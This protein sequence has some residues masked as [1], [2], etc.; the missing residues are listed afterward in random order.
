M[1]SGAIHGSWHDLERNHLE[2]VDGKFLPDPDPAPERPQVLFAM[3]LAGITV[4][5]DYIEQCSAEARNVFN[6]RFDSLLQRL[7]HA[8]DLHEEFL[9][10]QFDRHADGLAG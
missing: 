2:L 5:A 1:G 3:A 10:R 4:A 7:G 6:P 8:N 9:I